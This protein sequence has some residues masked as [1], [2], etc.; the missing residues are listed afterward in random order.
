MNKKKDE[1]SIAKNRR[2]FHE[3]EIIETWEAGIELTGCEV[4]SLRENNCQL[5]DC[6]VLIRGGE[7]WLNNVHIPPY[8]HGT[9]NNPDPDRKRK[10]LMHKKQ[11]RYLHGKVAEKG[12]AIVPLKMYFNDKGLV[13]V[14][15]ALARGKKL[16][17]KRQSMKERD[18]KREIDRVLK[19]RSR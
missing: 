3:Y 7:V 17:D 19:E 8:S 16:H 13:K 2:A 6:F 11:I 4:R 14:E 1:K 12:L 15:V 9:Y 18:T 10:L 5:T